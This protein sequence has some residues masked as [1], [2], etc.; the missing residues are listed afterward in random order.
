MLPAEADSHGVVYTYG[1]SRERHPALGGGP[2]CQL[3]WVAV[4]SCL[5][6]IVRPSMLLEP[7]LSL[8]FPSLNSVT[9]CNLPGDHAMRTIVHSRV[10][11]LSKFS[12]LCGSHSLLHAEGPN[13]A[14]QSFFEDEEPNSECSRLGRHVF[15][16]GRRSRDSGRRAERLPAR[17]IP[18]STSRSD[19]FERVVSR[20][21]A[22]NASMVEGGRRIGVTK[23]RR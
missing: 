8:I 14:S 16:R 19:V 12:V 7:R 15:L 18:G 6:C 20:H 9:D 10:P 21:C 5:A 2:C 11:G 13:Q 1:P 3:P 22:G 17:D 4:A 23:Y